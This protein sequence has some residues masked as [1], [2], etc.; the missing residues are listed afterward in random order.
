MNG[1][2]VELKPIGWLKPYG[3]NAKKHPPGQVAKIAASIREFG[4]NQP[5]V[6]D[7]EG[8]V[9]VG[10]GRLLAAKSIGMAEVPVLVVGDMPEEKKMA[11][12]LADNRLNES[13]W[14][15]ELLIS[16]LKLLPEAM[17]DLAGFSTDLII[18]P[19]ESDDA[20]GPLPEAPQSRKGD[21]YG[22]GGHILMCGDSTS[23][24]DVL[25]LTGG[26]K[27]DMVFT[28]PP[29]NVAYEGE[30]ASTSRGIMNDD[31]ADADFSGFLDS[32]FAVLRENVADH[33]PLYV[34]HASKTQAVFEAAMRRAGFRIRAQI[35][36]N[37][38]QF[39]LGRGDYHFKHEPCFYAC[40]EGSSPSFHGDRTNHTVWDLHDSEEA[41]VRWAKSVKKAEAEGRTTVWSMA[42]EP[43]SEYVHPTQKPVEL[44]RRALENS[45]RPGDT[46]LDLFAG[47]GSTLVAC[48]K[49]GR[50]CLTMELDPA[51]CDVVVSRWCEYAGTDSVILNGKET[52]WKNARN[53]GTSS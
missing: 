14:D 41:L 22:L 7:E 6:A 43:S 39:S 17:V 37:K 53:A 5:V 23:R 4:F 13:D 52:I 2:E 51:F 28:D 42:R 47:S 20:V 30:G 46:V 11:Y 26:I 48:E 25:K 32:L 38:P 27:V 45:S 10:H 21:V 19:E 35:I 40:V 24:E 50:K 9:I 44:I 29:Y 8:T 49:M 1:T 36:W 34:F 12:R 18:E 33:C 31:M 16:E 15:Q 3:R